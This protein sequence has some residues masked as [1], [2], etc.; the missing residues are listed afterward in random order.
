MAAVVGLTAGMSAQRRKAPSVASPAVVAAPGGSRPASRAEALLPDVQPKGRSGDDES[1]SNE[2]GMHVEKTSFGQR[3]HMDSGDSVAEP[4][5]EGKDDGSEGV[6]GRV[7]MYEDANGLSHRP[8]C[9]LNLECG[10][11][12]VACSVLRVS[13]P[14]K[15]TGLLKEGSIAASH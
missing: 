15:R 4:A 10:E 9:V 12:T 2:G 3:R 11:G 5:A 6:V 14:A 13:A 1:S 7:L 8:R